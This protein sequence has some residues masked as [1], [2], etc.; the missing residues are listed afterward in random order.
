ME[1]LVVYDNFQ[2]NYKEF[3]YISKHNRINARGIKDEARGE[4]VKKFGARAYEYEIKQL[5]KEIKN[6]KY[7]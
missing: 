5:Y 1:V 2:S 7:R 4:L 6:E 3:R